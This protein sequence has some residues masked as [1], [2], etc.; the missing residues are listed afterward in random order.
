MKTTRL[1]YCQFLLS[2]QTNYT[3][4]YFSDHKDKLDENSVYRYLKGEKLTPKLIWEKAQNTIVLDDEGYILFDDTVLNKKYSRQI[5]GARRQWS[6]NEKKI[7]MG[8]GVVTCVYYNPKVEKYWIID[9]RIFDPDRDGKTKIQHVLDMLKSLKTRKIKFKKVLMDSWY[10]A[11]NIMMEIHNRGKIFYCPMKCN[12]KTDDTVKKENEPEHKYVH[13]QIQELEWSE[14]GLRQGKTVNLHGMS[15]N[16][17]LFRIIVANDKIEYI[18]TNDMTQDSTN[19]VREESSIRWKIEQ[20][21]REAKQ[22][23]GLEKS[24]C[25][26]NRSQRNHICCAMLVWHR[27]KELAW[28]AEKTIYQV[29]QGM[30]KNYMVQQLKTPSVVFA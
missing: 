1:D 12:R 22:T 10:A 4:T 27:L 19:A 15:I 26:K 9:Y 18:V 17:K 16:L 24:Q 11:K 25:R 5:E 6:G 8:I 3:C 28:E 2:T 13:K 14:E 30:L 29:K 7:I 21:H 23:T 20:F